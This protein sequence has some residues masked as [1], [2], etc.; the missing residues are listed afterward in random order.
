[1]TNIELIQKI[2]AEIERRIEESR[3]R[4]KNLE[5]IGQENAGIVEEHIRATLKALLTFLSTIE[6]EEPT[7]P[8]DLDNEIHRFFD[9]CIEVYEV[10][11]C[12]KVKERVITVDC[13]EI[14][15]SHFAKWGAEHAKND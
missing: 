13:Y 5:D 7:I 8:D 15:A 3:T 1:M 9:E 2:R 6:S 4:Q 11:L 14:T 10:P 12:G